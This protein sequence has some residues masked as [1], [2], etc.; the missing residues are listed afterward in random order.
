MLRRCEGSYYKGPVHLP[1]VA[2]YT[3]L[4]ELASG[5]PASQHRLPG[6]QHEASEDSA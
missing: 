1:G 2:F 4:T 3:D 6:F 5:V